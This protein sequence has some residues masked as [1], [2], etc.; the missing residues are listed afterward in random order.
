M[1]EIGKIQK[2][3]I[4]RIVSNGAY[5]DAGTD[6]PKDSILLPNNQLP[7]DVNVGDL[8]EVFIYRDSKDR[9]IA[10]MKKPLGQVGELAYLKVVSTTRIGAF[11]DWGLEKDLFLPFS[12]QK[13]KVQVGRSYLVAIYVDKTDRLCATTDIYS[14]LMTDSPF[15]KGDRVEGT[16]YLVKSDVGALVAVDNKYRGLIPKNEYF[17]DIRNGDIVDVR[18]IRVKEDGKLDLSP[19]KIAYKQIN[20]DAEIII[21]KIKDGD[22]FLQLDDKSSPIDIKKQLN[23]SKSAFKKAVGKLLKE[24]KVEKTEEGLKIK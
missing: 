10:T 1:I 23:I 17:H 15:K 11:L 4:D 12:E 24:N 21:E 8:L 2:L 5:L 22:G 3:R 16:V 14:Y 13:Y 9:I 19:R 7:E 6:N 20:T 18:I